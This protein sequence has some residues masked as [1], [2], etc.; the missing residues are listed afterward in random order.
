[1]IPIEFG[2]DSISWDGVRGFRTFQ[3]RSLIGSCFLSGQILDFYAGWMN[4]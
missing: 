2:T 4:L 1:M 3:R